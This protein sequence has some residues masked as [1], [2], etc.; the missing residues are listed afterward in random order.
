MSALGF[1]P[2][3][4]SRLILEVASAEIM[5]RYRRLDRD[6]WRE[7]SPGDIVTIA[8]ER[9]EAAL[10]SRLLKLVPG[11]V[12]VGEESV[13][14]DPRF[15]DRLAGQAPAW[16]VD[17]IDGTQNFAEGKAEFCVMV[18]LA[19]SDALLGAWIHAPVT[20]ATA[21]AVKGEGA[22]LNNLP[23]PPLGPANEEIAG[24]I[25]VGQRGGPDL[26][27]RAQTLRRN[28]RPVKSLRC[29][30]L[31]Y[32]RMARGDLDFTLFSGV[33][34]WD[35][36]PGI[37]ILNELGCRAGYASGEN[38]RPSAASTATGVLAAR[39]ATTWSR[40]LD[41]LYPDRRSGIATQERT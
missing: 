2:D 25:A 34:P 33:M 15:L 7:K 21:V 22:R 6:D 32:L 41:H 3:I 30:G 26:I 18:A 38:Y 8:D 17:P 19:R 14:Q 5:P 4:V 36:A 20:G 31:D 27:A 24:V 10:A 40:V 12:L 28:A 39:D 29:A 11:S 13:A 9:A 16:I 37:A 35:H 23:L 1:D